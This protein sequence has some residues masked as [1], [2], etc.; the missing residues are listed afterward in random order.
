M[1]QVSAG[2][3]C[4]SRRQLL[5]VRDTDHRLRN[6]LT[7]RFDFPSI[8]IRGLAVVLPLSLMAVKAQDSIGVPAGRHVQRV[9]ADRVQILGPGDRFAGK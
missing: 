1:S 7:R 8:R 3:C 9:F 6:Y 4:S 2:R 5:T